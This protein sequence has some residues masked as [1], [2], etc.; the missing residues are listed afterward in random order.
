MRDDARWVREEDLELVPGLRVFFCIRCACVIRLRG[1]L[2]RSR[3]LFEPDFDEQLQTLPNGELV[4]VAVF[5]NR[6]ALYEF[7]HEVGAARVGGAGVE[8]LGDVRM[9]HQSQS[10]SFRLKPGDHEL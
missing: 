3:R 4:V 2:V 7:H 5:S 9:I 8:H 10:L 6:D 1:R